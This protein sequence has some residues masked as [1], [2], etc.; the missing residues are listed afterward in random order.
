[1]ANQNLYRGPL[2][3]NYLL[4]YLHTWTEK[5]IGQDLQV[6]QIDYDLHSSMFLNLKVE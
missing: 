2:F 5:G 6:D 4:D 3:F 1:M